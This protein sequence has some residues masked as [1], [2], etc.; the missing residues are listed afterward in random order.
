[1]DTI[2]HRTIVH[3]PKI[4]WNDV[5]VHAALNVDLYPKLQNTKIL[6]HFQLGQFGKKTEDFA[7]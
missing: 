1:M 6:K 7:C 3:S 5:V 4:H 2:S